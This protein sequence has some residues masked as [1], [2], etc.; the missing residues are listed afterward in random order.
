MRNSFSS[1]LVK[2]P[3]RASSLLLIAFACGCKAKDPVQDLSVQSQTHYAVP[4]PPEPNLGKRWLRVSLQSYLGQQTTENIS[5]PALKLVSTGRPLVIRD[6]SG[7]IFEN[8]EIKL[9]WRQMPLA[10]PYFLERQVLGPF[11]SFE[12]AEKVALLFRKEGIKAVVA[13]PKEWE[14][15]ISAEAQSL[16][17]LKTSFLRQEIS[18]LIVPILELG[19]S[20]RLLRGPIEIEAP[21]GL[22]WNGGVYTGFFRLQRDSYG[23]W[24]LV[25]QTKLDDYLEGVVPHEIGIGSPFVAMA[26]QA[27][28]AR[29]WAIANRHR[30]AVDGYH[31]CSDTQCQ[32]YRDPSIASLKVKQAIRTTSGNVLSWKGEPIKAFYHASNGGVMAS[33]S[34]SWAI[35]SLPYLKVQL[36]G[37]EDWKKNFSVPLKQSSEVLKLL[38]NGTGAYGEQHSRFR[39]T[40]TITTNQIQSSLNSFDSR[41]VSPIE[42]RILER[43]RSGRVIALELRGQGTE[44]PVVLRFDAIRRTFPQLPS[45][46]FVLDSLGKGSWSF[47]G[48]GFGHGVGLSQAGAIDL[49][50][51][52]WSIERIFSYYYP[53]T[54]YGPLQSSAKA[55]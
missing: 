11:A 42:M 7:Q 12:S 24:T 6:K 23:S 55:L 35:G 29:T 49:A 38:E 15:W 20:E 30:F 50:G 52:G 3:F 26:V 9:S 21:D 36:D 5:A 37:P 41:L 27:V 8:Q 22:Q 16:F 39:W 14:V 33:A 34:E 45:T 31:L 18:F 40:R 2:F 43:G 1:L 25:H 54:K 44:K 17:N 48:G 19:N 47:L 46:L 32:V 51:Q 53:G 4:L 28:L 10:T 13:R